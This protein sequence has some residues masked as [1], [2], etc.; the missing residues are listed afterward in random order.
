MMVVPW[1]PRGR[2]LILSGL[3]VTIGAAAFA[4]Y[5]WGM[6]QSEFEREHLD[7]LGGRIKALELELEDAGRRLADADLA[8]EVDRQ[9]LAIQREEMTELRGTARELREQLGFYRRVMDTPSTG[10]ALD[11]ADFELS[12]LEDSRTFRYRLLLT[13]PTEKGD[14]VR[15]AARVEVSGLTGDSEQHLS[16]PEI[17]DADSYPLEY[18]FRYFQRLT[19]SL[20]L[21]EGFRPLRVTV[22]L[23]PR[24]A[25][26]ARVERTFNWPDTP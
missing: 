9:A 7:L 16:L 26:T 19:G 14:W 18:R 5:L 17:S 22:R 2:T 1:T 15:G 20:T 3:T 12:R 24:G 25:D 23:F 11:V 8:R 10:Q 4:G 21:P 13:R 6:R